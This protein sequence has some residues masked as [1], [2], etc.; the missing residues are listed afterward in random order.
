MKNFLKKQVA[1]L[2]NVTWP[3]KKQ[4]I[5][6]MITVIVVM[7]LVGVFLGIVDYVFNEGVLF[8]LNK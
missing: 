2:H 6:S 4:A 1:E 5:H 8:M 3:T 7:M